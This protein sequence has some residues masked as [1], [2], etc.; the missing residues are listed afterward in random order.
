MKRWNELVLRLSRIQNLEYVVISIL[1]L[2]VKAVVGLVILA[3]EWLF[4]EDDD[5]IPMAEGENQGVR[6][7]PR[8]TTKK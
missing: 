8:R 7:W 6:D 2:P 1:L 4:R 5:V 3:A